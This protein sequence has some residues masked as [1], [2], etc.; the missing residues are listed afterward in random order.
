MLVK[1][2]LHIVKQDLGLFNALGDLRQDKWKSFKKNFNITKAMMN[3]FLEQPCE[4][5]FG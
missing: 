3:V 4:D 5:H 2:E 1:R